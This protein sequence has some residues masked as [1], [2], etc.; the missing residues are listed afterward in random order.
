M[1]AEPPG[2]PLLPERLIT[3]EQLSRAADALDH[4]TTHGTT[5]SRAHV[6][7]HFDQSLQKADELW[8]QA[9]VPN[10]LILPASSTEQV[11]KPEPTGVAA[12][13]APDAEVDRLR[14][15][16]DWPRANARPTEAAPAARRTKNTPGTHRRDDRGRK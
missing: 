13:A 15:M 10:G 7:A 3:L 5:D 9:G 14:R 1:A 16:V 11:G 12:A 8:Q 2:K 6:Q 4:H